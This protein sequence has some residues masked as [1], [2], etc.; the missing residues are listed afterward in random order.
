MYN[1][2]V[3]KNKWFIK[4]CYWMIQAG[5]FDNKRFDKPYFHFCD[6]Y[7]GNPKLC[8]LTV[9][10]RDWWLKQNWQRSATEALDH[11]ALLLS[12]FYCQQ[13]TRS[14]YANAIMDLE[15]VMEERGVLERSM[16]KVLKGWQG[17]NGETLPAKGSS[18]IQLK[19]AP[20]EDVAVKWL[21]TQIKVRFYEEDSEMCPSPCEAAG[22]QEG[23]SFVELPF[24]PGSEVELQVIA[25]QNKPF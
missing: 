23:G 6:N 10:F 20:A 9:H 13:E 15:R 4:H 17:T 14:A 2:W 8:A 16:R 7:D 3:G 22:G 1:H 11:D 12:F 25:I 5:L 21:E 19:L 18:Q 24:S